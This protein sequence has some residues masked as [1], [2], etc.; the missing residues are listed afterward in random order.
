[1]RRVQRVRRARVRVRVQGGASEVRRRCDGL[2]RRAASDAEVGLLPVTCFCTSS[3]VIRPPSPD[4]G[5]DVRSTPCSA[6][7]LRAVAV[8]RM[9]AAG[10]TGG[11]VR[12]VRRVR[13]VPEPQRMRACLP[14]RRPPRTWA[15][16]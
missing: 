8:A 2:A 1:M 10:A 5:T 15:D 3:F 9:S 6:A 12:Q 13:E 16:R 7:T 11:Q 4:P 14:E